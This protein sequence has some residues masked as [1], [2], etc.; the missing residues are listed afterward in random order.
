MIATQHNLQ[1]HG[2][3]L[4]C[5]MLLAGLLLAAIGMTNAPTETLLP[6]DSRM[7]W[8]REARFGLFVHWGLYAVPGGEWGAGTD[9][10]EWIMNEAHIPVPEYEK[11]KDQFNP[12]KF[13]ADEWVKMA[14]DAGMK[15][16]VITTKHHDGFALFNSR[17]SD[18]DV[19]AT[20][21][22]RDIMKE[23]AD[24]CRNQGL[25]ICWYHSIMDWHHPDYLP[26][27]DWEE[28]S[29][30][31]ADFDRYVKYLHAQVTELLTNYGDIGVMW[32]DGEWEPTWNSTYGDALY[33]LCR[34]LQPNVIVNNRVTVGRDGIA[35]ATKQPVGDFGTPEQYIPPEGIAGLDW[36]T[37]MTMG[38]HWGYN[39]RDTYKTPR[40]LVRNL[41]DIASKGGNY[42]LNVGPR[43]DGTL[44]DEAVA[45][46]KNYS[47]WMSKNGESIY[48][49]SA[50]PLGALPWGRCTAK[51][52]DGKWRLYLHVFDWPADGKLRVP[53]IGNDGSRAW[54]L[55][56]R[57]ALRA[58]KSGNDILI[59]VPRA[60]RDEDATV[61][62][63]EV[64]TKPI[65]FK[66]PKI[67]TETDIFVESIRVSIGEVSEGVEVHYT[68]DGSDPG[69]S[70]PKYV[71]PVTV[72]STGMFR[73][74]AFHEGRP[75]SDV[76][77]KRIVRVEPLP[78]GSAG[79]NKGLARL[80]FKGDWSKLPDFGAMT[81]AATGTTDKVQLGE[82]PFPE[83]VGLRLQGTVEVP[84][85]DVYRFSLL[86]DDG[87]RLWID[88]ELVVDNDGLHS[89]EGRVGAVAL[90][91]GAHQLRVDYFNK[92]GGSALALSMARSG[93]A[94]EEVQ[95]SAFRH[96]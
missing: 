71:S 40:D 78:A 25:K 11:F 48:A 57:D 92:T 22:K 52:V 1:G 13:H 12:V 79:K 2:R 47:R 35:D 56:G 51:Q 5:I 36:E 24:A 54:M 26:R 29:A 74:R 93:K 18:Y 67:E 6:V 89:P 55:D 81:P 23:M 88:G 27:R 90:A 68:T 8:W 28:R 14:K 94:F 34:K 80:A 75:V 59:D 60:M 62:V 44:P 91:K 30:L 69:T 31:G 70:S 87:A 39:K 10:G 3:I 84:A 15:Y 41:I 76:S 7:D 66:A 96:D 21:F 72:S 61:V 9:Y 33:A 58:R 45:I 73:A 38:R 46:L 20:P 4:P 86:S 63:L 53:L 16:I 83:F 19:M 82:Q 64:P 85:T 43:P 17:V 77:E 95:S 37:C 65:V 50:S 49:T 42:L 32:F